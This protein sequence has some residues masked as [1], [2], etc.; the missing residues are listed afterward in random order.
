MKN[1]MS[2]KK[3]VKVV[4]A[5]TCFNRREK[6]LNC[7]KKLISENKN[8]L[9]EFVIVDDNSSDGTV[10]AL[11]ELQEN[12]TIIQSEGN[13]FYSRGMRRA[14]EVVQN[15]EKYKEDNYI[16]LVNDDVDFYSNSIENIINES[17]GKYVIVGATCNSKGIQ[18]Y[19]AVRYP[20][21]NSVKAEKIPVGDKKRADTFNANCVLIP[22]EI[23]KKVGIMD[24]HY[25]H[26]LGDYDYGFSISKHGYT[27]YSSNDYVGKCDNNSQENTWL[28]KTLSVKTRIRKKE[29]VK[30]SPAK[31][32]WYYL[33]KNFG[34]FQAV[35]YSISPYVKI[36]L[37]K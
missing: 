27:I 14:M 2:K 1:Y 37:K 17:K 21:K 13:L 10:A 22:M 24:S 20:K 30:G 4:V 6:T 32:W 25:I 16:L 28:D 35:K 12:I 9:F 11:N 8:V 15:E 7:V 5:L 29:S 18:S 26:G 36:L 19:G 34:L 3:C 23:F 33:K 31:I